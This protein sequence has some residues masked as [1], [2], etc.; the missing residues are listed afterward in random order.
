M[1]VC[2][3]NEKSMIRFMYSVTLVTK[4]P[5]NSLYIKVAGKDLELKQC[6]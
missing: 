3:G 1:G 2:G 4:Q 5:N 6:P